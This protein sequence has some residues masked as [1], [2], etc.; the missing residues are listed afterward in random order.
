MNKVVTLEGGTMANE[1]VLYETEGPVA[2]VTMNRPEQL[3]AWSQELM[4]AFIAALARARDDDGV[5]AVVITGAGKGFC[6]GGDLAAMNALPTENER[7]RFFENPRTI[8]NLIQD[9]PKPVI[10]MVNGVAAGAG[11]NLALVCDVTFASDTAKFVQSFVKVGLAPD[12]GGFYFLPRTV[13]LQKAKELMFTAKMLAADEA[14]T[15]GLIARVVPAADLRAETL[16]FAHALAGGAPQA[17]AFIKRALQDGLD[18]SLDAT[19]KDEALINGI[20][21]GTADFA[22]GVAAFTTKRPPRF[23]GK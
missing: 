19:L 7:R 9:T 8:V 15:L 23:T 5:R 3:N 10:A 13:G 18:K 22:E 17:I 21:A 20:L 11:F 16:A 4:D 6:A 1:V 14:L 12:T 2:I